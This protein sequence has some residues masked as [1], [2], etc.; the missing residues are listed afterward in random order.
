[1]RLLHLTDRLSNRGGADWHL[2]GVL[3][4]LVPDH[5]VVLVV[6][7]D[8]GSTA[9]PCETIIVPALAERRRRDVD[10]ET[11]YVER[12]PDLIHVH[13]VVNPAVL[14][15]AADHGAV[16]TVQDHRTFCP[17]RGKL[18][19]AGAVCREPMAADV[20]RPCFDDATYF[21]DILAQTFDRLAALRRMRSTVLSDYMKREL[22]AV[23][24]AAHA[25]EV[26]PPF[27]VGLDPEARAGGPPC[28]LY[29]GRVV[30]AKGVMDAVVAWRRS[31]VDLPMVVAGT[32]SERPAVEAA[33]CDVT[34]WLSHT[35]LSGLYRRAAVV[36]LPSRW[37]EPFGIVGL[38]ALSLGTPVVAWE[39]GGVR[40]WHPGEGLV[41]WGDVDGLAR[42]IKRAVDR[43]VAPPVGFERA[44]LMQRLVDL[45]ADAVQ[46]RP[47]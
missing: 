32:G 34:G 42:E 27:V 44:P 9:A 5:D 33:G 38:E 10:L 39:S 12:A 36:V 20:C 35:E 8:D 11:L 22:I 14:D 30:A 47:G 25:I 31:G 46:R 24:C 41:P 18:T 40:E 4:A 43:K 3:D 45:Y 17:G 19:L 16:M 15:W 28:I 37:Q 26:I 7:Q 1:M 21:D 6:G 13:N 23:G 2:L 29:V